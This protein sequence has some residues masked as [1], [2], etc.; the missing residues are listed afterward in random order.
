MGAVSLLRYNVSTGDWV[1]MA[2]VRATRPDPLGVPRRTP[3]EPPPEHDASCPFCPGNE[4]KTPDTI[5]E[6]PDPDD[7]TRW[8]VRLCKNKFPALRED[9][10]TER[11]LIGPLFREMEGHGRHEILIESPH[12]GL[13]LWDQAPSQVLRVLR[14]LHR[15]SCA[16]AG[17]SRLEV[18]QIFKNHGTAAGSSMPHPHFQIIATPIVPRQIRIKFQMAAEHYQVT[19]QSVYVELC[20]A[21]IEAGV[22]IVASNDAYVAF[23][24]F[25]SRV[26]YETWVLPRQPAPTFDLADPS[27][28]PLLGEMIRDVLGRLRTVLDDPPFNL[29]INSAPRR[30]ADEP[31]FV[32]HIEILPRLSQPAGFELSTGMSINS[33]A[34]EIA[35][36]RLRGTQASP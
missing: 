11:R 24:P 17:D 6:E 36:E 18:V 33:V 29:V 35:A 20:H 5:D 19:G 2:S 21:E 14:V 7:P 32:W 4:G 13:S 25:A 26:P 16:L 30:H 1:V 9:L 3:S 12:H 34:P 28:L 10:P 23:T 22:R 31:D 15:R 8:S 27:T